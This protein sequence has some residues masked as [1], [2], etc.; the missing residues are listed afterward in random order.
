MSLTLDKFFENKTWLVVT[1]KSHFFRSTYCLIFE[2]FNIIIIFW[3]KNE[4]WKSISAHH[5]KSENYWEE[6]TWKK[7]ETSTASLF[8]SINRC[9]TNQG[10]KNL[11]GSDLFYLFM[12]GLWCFEILNDNQESEKTISKWNWLMP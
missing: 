6:G 10:G 8:L 2:E 11:L 1:R 12:L 3:S 5:K 4:N 9:K 7:L